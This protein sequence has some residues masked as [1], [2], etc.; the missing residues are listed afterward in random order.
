MGERRA[1]CLDDTLDIQV[2][3]LRTAPTKFLSDFDTE[4]NL[5]YLLV[6]NSSASTYY[7]H[8]AKE[9]FDLWGADILVNGNCETVTLNPSADD[10]TNDIWV[11]SWADVSGGTGGYVDATAT[12]HAGTYGIK[13]RAANDGTRSYFDNTID[14]RGGGL[15]DVGQVITVTAS[16]NYRLSFWTR[17][18]VTNAGAYR[19]KNVQNDYYLQANGTW[20]ASE[21]WFPT[22]V[23]GATYIEVV[24]QFTT[25]TGAT[26]LL[27]AFASAAVTGAIAYFD[28]ISL[29]KSLTKSNANIESLEGEGIG[30]VEHGIDIEA[31]GGGVAET[32]D[33]SFRVLNQDEIS[34]TYKN[35]VFI[36]RGVQLKMGFVDAT[37]G[38]QLTDMLMIANYTIAEVP[39]FQWQRMEFHCV[40]P[41]F[42]MNTTLPDIL[43]TKQSHPRAPE[44][45]LGKCLPYLYGDFVT[46]NTATVADTAKNRHF[47]LFDLAPTI[48]TS[49]GSSLYAATNPTHTI[50]SHVCHTIDEKFLMSSDGAMGLIDE[51]DITEINTTYGGFDVG[52]QMTCT[53]Y[54]IPESNS[55][56]TDDAQAAGNQ[57][58]YAVDKSTTS[59][60]DMAVNK[61][62]YYKLNRK[63]DGT[64][65]GYTTAANAEI[66]IYTLYGNISAT[67]DIAQWAK[68]IDTGTYSTGHQHS[69]NANQNTVRSV[70]TTLS[71]TF[72]WSTLLEDWEFGYVCTVDIGAVKHTVV[73][74]KSVVVNKFGTIINNRKSVVR[75][76]G[77]SRW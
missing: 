29:Q 39:Y 55:T 35:E 66:E 44:E 13:I 63:G 11:D 62:L 7:W 60:F 36:N 49:Y 18:D 9:A 65:I 59:H 22:G 47:E 30:N 15:Y 53:W 41:M 5:F 12:K 19:I 64:L 50:A 32:G 45:S 2:F 77:V 25:R 10:G 71:G 70:V 73:G 72:D 17:G 52:K 31:F 51:G 43:V 57:F 69:G 76:G 4:K 1:R 48:V 16:T 58:D 74:L 14:T 27:I 68:I 38:V 3:K 23:A 61:A 42:Q 20:A 34:D 26:T 75:P 21:Y 24:K 6:V 56:G 33:F 40:D 37:L 28:D 8:T 54:I 67:G 46:F